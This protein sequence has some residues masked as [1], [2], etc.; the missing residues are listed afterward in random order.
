[1]NTKC[2]IVGLALIGV[3]VVGP[4]VGRADAVAG[5]AVF[6]SRCANCHSLTPGL[7]SIAPDLM[8]VVGRKAGSLKDYRYSPALHDADFV[9]TPEKLGGWLQSPHNAVPETEM[10]FPGLKD[11]KERAEVVEFLKQRRAK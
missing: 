3:G 11:E 8:G 7:S 1:M 10:S 5:E 4:S 2:M 9:W 6:K